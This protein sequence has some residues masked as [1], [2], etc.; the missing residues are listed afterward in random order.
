MEFRDRPT[1]AMTLSLQLYNKSIPFPRTNK[2]DQSL[3]WLL[4]L[5][6]ITD[7]VSTFIRSVKHADCN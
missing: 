2:R 1:I 3:I 6:H 7:I 5:E 4:G